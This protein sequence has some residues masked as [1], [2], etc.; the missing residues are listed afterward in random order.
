MSV[1]SLDDFTTITLDDK[2]V[3]DD[4]YRQYPPSHSSDLF[5]T[6]VSWQNYIEYRYTVR[7]QCLLLMSGK[8][9]DIQLRVPVGPVSPDLL[10]Q[11]VELSAKEQG[12][13]GFIK[14]PEKQILSRQFPSLTFV[15]DRDFFDYVYKSSDLAELSG[16]AYA[17]IRNRLN[18]FTKSVYYE[19]EDISKETMDEV[20]EF[21]KRW[22]LWKDC[23][24]DEI[25]ENERKAILFC[26]SHFFDLGLSGIMIR[27]NGA[28]E[29]IAV[30]EQMNVDTAVVHFEKGSPDY[31]GIYKA[32]NMETAQRLRHKVSYIDREEDLGL[33]GLRKAKLSYHPHHFIEVYHTPRIVPDHPVG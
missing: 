20:G 2:A 33:P 10:H 14:A 29:A 25:L 26:M 19:V 9:H 5:T 1:L 13:I 15:K 7:D 30:F 3:F 24:S 16:T 6:L 23:E 22:C 27:I 17:K 18:K 4:F 28:I 11:V 32:V 12:T 21:L 31:D 8:N